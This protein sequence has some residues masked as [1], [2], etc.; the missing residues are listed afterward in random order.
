MSKFSNILKMIDILEKEKEPIKI[1]ELAEKI[2]VGE[3]MIRKYIND[4]KESQIS[5]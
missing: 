4:L 5:T 2:Q 3:R 1:K